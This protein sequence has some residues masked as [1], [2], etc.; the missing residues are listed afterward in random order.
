MDAEMERQLLV[1]EV[2]NLIR[3]LTDFGFEVP[4]IDFTKVS[5]EDLRQYAARFCHMATTPRN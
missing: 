2:K 5:T 1:T 4:E 3:I